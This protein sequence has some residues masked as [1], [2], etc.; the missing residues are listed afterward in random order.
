M[1]LSVS[2]SLRLRSRKPNFDRDQFET[3]EAMRSVRDSYMDDGHIA[4]CI[5]DGTTYR[6]RHSN[7]FDPST[8]KWRKLIET[9]GLQT[10]T[11]TADID[12]DYMLEENLE[13]N[14]EHIY[15]LSIAGSD[16]NIILPEGMK[17]IGGE[18]PAG[19]AASNV[20]VVSTLNGFAV[21]GIFK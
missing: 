15:Y 12:G 16:A 18:A 8:G 5:E 17:W 14:T 6:F 19:Y 21:W 3:L 20:V 13:Q 7:Q 11:F 4:F 10:K 2:D 9:N 1:A